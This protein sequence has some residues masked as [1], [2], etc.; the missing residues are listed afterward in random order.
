MASRALVRDDGVGV[1]L[2]VKG[3][4]EAAFMSGVPSD[5]HQ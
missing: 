2:L 4:Y 3:I 5:W 1:G